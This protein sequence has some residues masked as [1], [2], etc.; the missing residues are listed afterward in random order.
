MSIQQE[1]FLQSLKHHQ[2]VVAVRTNTADDTNH[3]KIE[4]SCRCRIKERC[5][6]RQ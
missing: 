4:Q 1:D 5:D 3:A 6:G 2:L